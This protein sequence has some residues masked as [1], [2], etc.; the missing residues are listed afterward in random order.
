MSENNFHKE[1]LSEKDQKALSFLET[2]L[3][4]HIEERKKFS[5]K[6]GYI[7]EN[8]FVSELNLQELSLDLIPSSISHFHD[9]RKIRLDKNHLKDVNLTLL[10]SSQNLRYLDLDTNHISK[11][12]LSPLVKCKKLE[13]LSLERN[14]LQII[15]LSPLLSIHSLGNILLDQNQLEEINLSPLETSRKLFSLDLG[16]NKLREVDLSPLRNCNALRSLRLN[17]NRLQSLDLSSLSGKEDFGGLIL[18]NNEIKS[19]DITPLLSL[20]NLQTVIIDSETRLT[21]EP[22]HR[23]YTCD[24]GWFLPEYLPRVEWRLTETDA[25]QQALFETYTQIQQ[26][27]THDE[28]WADY[29]DRR[30]ATPVATD[31][32]AAF[33]EFAVQNYLQIKDR[34][35]SE[36]DQATLDQT[37]TQLEQRISGT[38]LTL[39][40]LVSL[41]QEYYTP[42]HEPMVAV[43]VVPAS[44]SPR[45]PELA[46][47]RFWASKRNVH[48]RLRVDS[49][50]WAQIEVD[51]PAQQYLVRLGFNKGF[52]RAGQKFHPHYPTWGRP[53]PDDWDK[54]WDGEERETL[55]P[56]AFESTEV[57]YVVGA[58]HTGDLVEVLSEIRAFLTHEYA[59]SYSDPEKLI[60]ITASYLSY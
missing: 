50:S 22:L 27:F 23:D 47:F 15:D 2:E 5:S 53:I 4:I 45:N 57:Q 17:D 39:E 33:F 48:S 11:I 51:E 55:P 30:L 24:H 25:P 3:G 21:A 44:I 19:L 9:L 10:A 42:Q 7:I 12:D 59:P 40:A 43:V 58:F 14:N 32:N 6:N 16:H 46:V 31:P 13:I 52:L 56:D 36:R 1:K 49:F 41:F 26:H 20:K 60:T 29:R 28:F 38:F 34:P 54:E 37:W 18:H 8:G 35:A